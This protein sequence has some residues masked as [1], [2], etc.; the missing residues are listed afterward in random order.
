[1][2]TSNTNE[3]VSVAKKRGRPRKTVAPLQ[4]PTLPRLLNRENVGV[5]LNSSRQKT[6]DLERS[7]PD[8]PAPLYVGSVPL[9]LE[10]EIA[11]YVQRKA[12]ARP[13]V[14]RERAAEVEE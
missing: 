1:M 9:W 11:A 6:Y 12:D 5:A 13:R 2:S 10:H 7:D 3:S 8:F 4:P 14:V